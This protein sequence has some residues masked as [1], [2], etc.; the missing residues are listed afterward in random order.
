MKKT[1][2]ALL[3]S[4]VTVL[5]LTAVA[6]A[7]ESPAAPDAPTDAQLLALTD[8]VKISCIA[9]EDPVTHV[10]RHGSRSYQLIPGTYTTKDYTG[11]DCEVEYVDSAQAWRYIFWLTEAGEKAY[12]SKFEQETNSSH[13]SPLP[14]TGIILVYRNAESG[15]Q[16]DAVDGA[17]EIRLTDCNTIP[18]PDAPSQDLIKT[19]KVFVVCESNHQ[20]SVSEF[21]LA[22]GTYYTD[23]TSMRWNAE[24][25]NRAGAWLYNVYLRQGNEGISPYVNPFFQANGKHLVNYVGGEV[26]FI[27]RSNENKW[28]ILGDGEYFSAAHIWVCDFPTAAEL[29]LNV[30]VTCKD[31][32]H[33]DKKYDTANLL[34]D[35]SLSFEP[36]L[37]PYSSMEPYYVEY[38]YKVFLTDTAANGY[39]ANYSTA[40]GKTHTWDKV[41]DSVMMC[42]SGNQ[43][44]NYSIDPDNRDSAAI[45]VYSDPA[46]D[47]PIE[48]DPDNP[49]YK[50]MLVEGSKNT[51]TLT[52]TDTTTTPPGGTGGGFPFKDSNKT[53]TTVSSPK[54]FDAGMAVYAG[55]A[56]LSLT[57][58]AMV[59]RKK[60]EF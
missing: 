20:H 31:G 53:T 40:V 28:E 4:L 10:T 48:V 47:P 49:D 17:A 2:T 56:I 8:V 46:N 3:L 45:A 37:I 7:T 34:A 39:A 24:Y 15:W 43:S 25:N 18:K 6:W 36:V 26:S 14:D 57:G 54:T 58:S 41:R 21:T 32:T 29:G 55:L 16:L 33:A 22:A 38:H 27:Y 13:Y 19:G 11:K 5:C 52:A 30:N 9:D 12:I 51:L 60:N 1:I 44:S 42:W 23:A 59:I 35:T 50:W